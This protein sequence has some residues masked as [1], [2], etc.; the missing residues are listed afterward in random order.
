M[1]QNST[2]TT[3]PAYLIVPQT[4]TRNNSVHPSGLTRKGIPLPRSVLFYSTFTPFTSLSR[5]RP[6]T[7]PSI[8]ATR[9]CT[10]RFLANFQHMYIASGYKSPIRIFYSVSSSHN[11]CRGLRPPISSVIH[12]PTNAHVDIVKHSDK[13]ISFPLNQSYDMNAEPIPKGR[14]LS[15]FTSHPPHRGSP[16]QCIHVVIS[17]SLPAYKIDAST[18]FPIVSSGCKHRSG[19]SA[20]RLEA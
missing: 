6:R 12:S 2:A 8:H 18:N 13:S 3:N 11:Y 20:M 5:S 1:P 4:F 19:N 7:Y 17:R 10:K 16:T 14:E 9:R 15:Q